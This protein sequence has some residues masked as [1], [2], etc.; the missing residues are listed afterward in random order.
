MGRSLRRMVSRAVRDSELGWR[1][2]FNRRAT[3]S[4]R[5]GRPRLTARQAR[6]LS[7]LD[8]R[9]IAMTS[10]E[11]LG[12]SSLFEELFRTVRED[13]A[14]RRE[15]LARA[16]RRADEIAG[17]DDK[18]FLF[19]L[20]GHWPRVDL[21]SVYLRFAL[22]E[23]ILRIANAYFGMYARLR[24]FNVWYNFPTTGAARTSQLWHKDREDRLILKVFVYLADVRASSGPFSYVPATHRKGRV[25]D[26]AESFLE[27]DVRRST[28]EQ[29]ARLVP[30]P[31]W[32]SAIGPVGTV[33][34]ADTHGYHKGGLVREAERVMYLCM[35][36]SPA[37]ESKELLEKP[38]DLV[39]PQ[40]PDQAFALADRPR[41]M[42]SWLPF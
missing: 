31:S 28:D 15:E 9:G 29:M 24:H 5:R 14:R 40:A 35:F 17:E 16:R 13:E 12:V 20:L 26:S 11:E 33:V 39:L 10:V 22:Q 27:G 6:L 4:Y 2:V 42:A 23:P 37:S 38:A 41:R 21:Q 36:T 25:R 8:R 18:A 1:F 30:Q 3:I 7:E 19:E 32:V 34:F